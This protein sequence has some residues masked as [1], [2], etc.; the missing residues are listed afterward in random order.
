M[1][2]ELPFVS[3]RASF[4]EGISHVSGQH[5]G[6]L[7]AGFSYILSMLGT[8]YVWHGKG[9]LKAE[10]ATASSYAQQIKGTELQVVEVRQG[11]EDENFWMVSRSD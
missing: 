8:I 6:N 2:D 7:C 11:K 5:I 1:I 9:S 4:I 3:E 10:R